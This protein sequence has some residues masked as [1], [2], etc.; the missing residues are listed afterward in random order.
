[1]YNTIRQLPAN[2]DLTHEYAT[3][4]IELLKDPSMQKSQ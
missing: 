1:M 4:C 3:M 2:A